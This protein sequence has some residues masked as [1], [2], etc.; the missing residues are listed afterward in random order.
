VVDRAL[1]EGPQT[2]TRHGV[3][4]AVVVSAT[5]YRRLR[6]AQPRS[7]RQILLDSVGRDR[8]EPD[9]ADLLPPRH[10]V[11]LRPPVE[12]DEL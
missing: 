3:E 7:L 8:G 1:S 2:I 9:F 11:S 5:E 10:T 12:F 4:A 6:Q